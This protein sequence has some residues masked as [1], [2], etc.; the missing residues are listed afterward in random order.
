MSY[1]ASSYG[2]DY[3]L[4]YKKRLLPDF[5]SFD[6]IGTRDDATMN[7]VKMCSQESAVEHNCDPSVF[8][9]LSSIP[10]SIENVKNKLISIGVDFNKPIIGLMCNDWLAK[11]VRE[12]LGNKYQYIA[13]Y[14]WNNYADYYADNLSPFEWA[15]VFGLFTATFTHYFHGTLFSL[16]NHALVFPIEKRTEYSLKYKTKILDVLDRLNL[17]DLHL[18]EDELNNDKWIDLKN[19]IQQ[20]PNEDYFKR[21][22]DGLSLERQSSKSFFNTLKD[23]IYE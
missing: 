1:A 11:I 22:D 4:C 8:L 7:F 19:R 21:I 17:S 14:C 15:T 12:N 10:V 20:G 6:Y 2:M 23:I 18:F 16:K 5:S 9:N 3:Q 13:L